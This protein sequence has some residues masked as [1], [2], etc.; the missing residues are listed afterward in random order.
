MIFYDQLTEYLNKNNE[1]Q[2]LVN[3]NGRHCLNY[4]NTLGKIRWTV[5]LVRPFGSER[6]QKLAPFCGF[7]FKVI[8]LSM[9][10]FYLIVFPKRLLQK[11]SSMNHDILGDFIFITMENLS[12]IL[13]NSSNALALFRPILIFII[14]LTQQCGSIKMI[15]GVFAKKSRNLRQSFMIKSSW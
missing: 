1:T 3:H 5:S 9:T 13:D 2:Q 15:N 10:S 12:I 8:C 6:I 4:L 14:Y 11:I 7:L